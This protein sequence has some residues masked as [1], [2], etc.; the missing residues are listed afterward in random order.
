MPVEIKR[1]APTTLPPIKRLLLSPES[2]CMAAFSGEIVNIEPA[3]ECDETHALNVNV[4]GGAGR[5]GEIHLGIDATRALR[6]LCDQVLKA[7][8]EKNN[9]GGLG[10]LFG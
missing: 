2:G 7:H 5:S 10:A 9:A 1:E 6:D 4:T 8:D 3:T